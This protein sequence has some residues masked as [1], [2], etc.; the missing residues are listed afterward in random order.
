[1]DDLYQLLREDGVELESKF[2]KASIEGRGT[3]QE[4]ADFREHAIQEFIE[5]FF[6]YPHRI[7]KGKIRDSFGSMSDSI[8]C[9]VCNPNHPYT[10]DSR[11]KFRLLL[12]EG[13]DAA[14]E[15][16]PD[17][18]SSAELIRGL[19][20]GLTVKQLKRAN[21]PTLMRGGWEYDRAFRVP[22]VMFAMRCK[23]DPIATGREIA[24]FY[25]ERQTEMLQQ[26][27]FVVVN[28]V[29]IFMNF[30]SESLYCWGNAETLPNRTGWFFEQWAENTLAGFVWRLQ[31][32]AHASIK[33]QDDV[34]PRYLAPKA[35][36]SVVRVSP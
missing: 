32:L 9:V 13:I 4:I 7:T 18:A 5:R 12:A 22:F 6:P 17:I 27:D 19:E 36:R 1:M 20:Q 29:G 34:L 26:A 35:I 28:G 31:L 15:I 21:P 11:G 14:V 23:A 16:K 8:D 24:A 2:R 25:G 10:V 3:S 33:M 30:T